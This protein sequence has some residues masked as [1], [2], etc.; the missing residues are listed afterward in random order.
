MFFKAKKFGPQA[1]ARVCHLQEG[2]RFR[3]NLNATPATGRELFRV[4]PFL[5]PNRTFRPPG[6]Q[7]R[8]HLLGGETLNRH[9][10][11]ELVFNLSCC[12]RGSAKELE[13]LLR[14]NTCRGNFLRGR[15]NIYMPTGTTGYKPQR[16]SL[17]WSRLCTHY[18]KLRSLVWQ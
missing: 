10:F 6:G 8:A 7:G 15:K 16:V 12:Q 1:R 13:V 14:F 9:L 4:D 3:L 5:F 2:T 11:L 17:W 18:A